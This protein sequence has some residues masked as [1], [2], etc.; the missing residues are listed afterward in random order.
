MWGVEGDVRDRGD[1]GVG[2]EGEASGM[3]RQLHLS[4]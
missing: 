2:D 3:F 1:R 4:D